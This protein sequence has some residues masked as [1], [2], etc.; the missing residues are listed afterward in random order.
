MPFSTKGK[1]ISRPGGHFRLR[2]RSKS[3]SDPPRSTR[4]EPCAPQVDV[5]SQKKRRKKKASGKHTFSHEKKKN[6]EGQER[7]VVDV[8]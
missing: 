7:S 6:R 3:H 4:I 1:L 2:T 5:H 8:S